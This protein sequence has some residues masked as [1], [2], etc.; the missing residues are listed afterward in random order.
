MRGASRADGARPAAEH[1]GAAEMR[2]NRAE[3]AVGI[4][5]PRS[6]PPVAVRCSAPPALATSG[7]TPARPLRLSVPLFPIIRTVASEY[8]CR[9]FRSSV[10]IIRTVISN[11]PCRYFQLPVPLF[12]TTRT[13]ISDHTHPYHQE[14]CTRARPPARGRTACRR[15]GSGGTRSPPPAHA[16]TRVST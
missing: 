13:V 3:S 14:P 11:Y 15:S 12:P 7:H 8:P 2:P 1:I 4:D 6:V 10:P 5:P 9:C 16:P